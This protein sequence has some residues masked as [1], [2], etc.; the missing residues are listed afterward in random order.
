MINYKG[1]VPKYIK[2]LLDSFIPYCNSI[3]GINDGV[4][5]DIIFRK[6]PKNQI[7]FV[8]FSKI[9]NGKNEIIIDSEMGYTA[10]LYT[11]A[12]EL[13]HIKQIKGGELS[14]VG[15]F[16]YW[17]SRVNI[18]VLEYNKISKNYDFDKYSKLE[19]EK[20]AYEN[21]YIIPK[22]FKSSNELS[23]LVQQTVEPNLKFI[24]SLI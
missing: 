6:V 4:N 21:M 20:E 22:Q 17:K 18:S 9:I 13:I 1:K 19:W 10:M 7:G 16:F 23:D 11:L 14:V 2:P 8:N 24:L 3:L 15:G 12:H 5:L